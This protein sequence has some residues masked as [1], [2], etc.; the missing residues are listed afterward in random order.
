PD[1]EI[2]LE[3]TDDLGNPVRET[4]VTDGNGDYQFPNLRP[5]RYK[6]VQPSQPPQTENGQT[7]PGSSGGTGTPKDEPI[8]TIDELVLE[9][10]A[11]SQANNFG[12][13]SIDLPDLRVSK[14]VTPQTLTTGA[15]A[16]YTIVV[17]N[18][19]TSQT[20]G[21]YQVRDR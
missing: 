7:V 3:G 8:S 1:Q 2:V 12:E 15:T 21:E 6:V 19:G 14:S 16:T 4:A 9:P 5:G 11:D 17:R 13:I 10:G 20:N 18:A